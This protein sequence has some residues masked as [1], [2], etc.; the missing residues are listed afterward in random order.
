MPMSPYRYKSTATADETSNKP[1]LVTFAEG[2]YT[3]VDAEVPAGTIDGVNDDFTLTEAPNPTDSLQL[4][5]N[6]MLMT[7]GVDYNLAADTITYVAGAI[8]QVGDAHVAWF[9]Y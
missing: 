9:R 5:K 8:P 4:Y 3:F 6:G 7:E 2:G 1:L